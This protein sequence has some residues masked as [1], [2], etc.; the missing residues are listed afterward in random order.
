MWLLI[1]LVGWPLTEIALFVTAGSAIGLWPTLA[2]VVGTGLL[3]LSILR[4]RGMRSFGQLRQTVTLQPKQP[5]GEGLVTMVA[6]ILLILPGFLT[7]ALGLLLLIPSVQRFV[8]HRIGEEMRAASVNWAASLAAN[9]MT[10]PHPTAAEPD[11]PVIEGEIVEMDSDKRP[12]QR[13]QA[14]R[15]IEKAMTCC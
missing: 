15:G 11:G 1:G 2:I 9:R 12:T 6:A 10:R 7:D 4:R 8:L 13:H 3:G 14:G 5:L